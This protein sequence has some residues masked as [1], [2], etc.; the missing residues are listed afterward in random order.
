M[1]KK[2]SGGTPAT[3]ALSAAGVP[4]T[5]RPY[6]HDPRAASYGLEAAEALGFPPEQ[7]FKTLVVDVAASGRPSLAVGVVPVAGQLD[8][9]AIAAALGAK[10]AV[11]ADPALAARSSGYVV[12]G[13]SPIGQR[14]PLPCVVD[15]SAL[16]HET[17]LV[18]GGRRGLDVELSPHDLVSLTGA[19]LAEIS[20]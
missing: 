5:L 15:A 7:V 9:K 17:V 14:T 1:A 13:I 16:L 12:G 6:D 3:D 10:K 11:M 8:L 19:T 2:A 18:S 4:F 20:R